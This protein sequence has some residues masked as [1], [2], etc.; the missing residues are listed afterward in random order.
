MLRILFLCSG[1]SCRSQM[2]EGWA[3]KLW[4]RSIEPHSAGIEA[5]GLDSI[6]VRVMAES[7]I[8][9]SG[10]RSKPIRELRELDFDAVITLSD[11]VRRLCPVFW[12]RARTIHVGLQ[13]PPRLAADA[14]TE[15]DRL[16]PYRQ[17]R[18]AIRFLVE[19]LPDYF[20][21]PSAPED[22]F[23]AATPAQDVWTDSVS[24]LRSES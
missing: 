15:E 5:H 22:T 19:S 16:T 14:L 18:D 17:A 4:P 13:S 7:D 8:D 10:Q 1:N 12:T 11:R 21:A 23:L 2:A 9:I 3:R 24:R 6:A 20:D